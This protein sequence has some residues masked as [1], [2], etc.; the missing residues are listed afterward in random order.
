M[1]FSDVI[2][3]LQHGDEGKGKIS[4][5]LMYKNNYDV[6][7][8]F[9]GGPN[10]GHTVYTNDKS[11][12]PNTKIILH[13]IPCGILLGKIAIIGS[14]CVVDYEKLIL[15][16][17]MLEK[18]GFK[19]V[20]Q[21]LFVS[22]NAHI[23]TKKHIEND[24]K[25]NKVGTTG[26]GIGPCYTD[27]VSRNGNRVENYKNEF[28]KINIQ[29]INIPQF[30]CQMY[31]GENIHILFEGA[32]GYMLDIDWGEYPY[33]TSSNCL[34]GS[35]VNC[36]IPACTLRHVYGVL[37]IYETYIGSKNFQSDDVD[38]NRL[39]SIGK[40]Y[41]NTT[42]RQRQCNWLNMDTIKHAVNTNGVTHLIF[43]K[44]DIISEINIFKL[45]SNKS[46][47]KFDSIQDMQEFIENDIKNMNKLYSHDIN[48]T[49][50]SSPYEI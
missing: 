19:N 27:K 16:I 37:K 39:I 23:I 4:Y 28:D 20:R 45:I 43:N 36:G 41:G 30:V 44:C 21:L 46:I 35:F 2:I 11:I 22:H 47:Y 5:H 12:V 9:N 7:I 14:G 31:Q 50:S 15:E 18:H 3:G 17:E 34:A 40:E 13:Q 33:V 10:A 38:L 6:N 26:C 1:I 42:G 48:F 49:Y 29:I 8:R 24:N 25:N 32:Q